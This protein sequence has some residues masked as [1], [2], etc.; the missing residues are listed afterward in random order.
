M[1]FFEIKVFV[2]SSRLSSPGIGRGAPQPQPERPGLG[3]LTTKVEP[4]PPLSRPHLSS[5]EAQIKANTLPTV[6][7]ETVNGYGAAPLRRPFN[8]PQVTLN[9]P[10]F[11]K[12][13]TEPAPLRRPYL[14]LN[15]PQTT[16]QSPVPS[17]K[18]MLENGTRPTLLERPPNESQIH[19]NGSVSLTLRRPKC[20]PKGLVMP[21]PAKA[22]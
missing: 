7:S 17:V 14:P 22:R 6:K 13:L 2:L 12:P 15:E 4:K 20:P 10:S 11:V 3:S 21:P 16:A 9:G 1:S 18:P 8:E 19:V 5:N